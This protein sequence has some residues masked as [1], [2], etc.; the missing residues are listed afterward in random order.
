MCCCQVEGTVTQNADGLE[1]IDRVVDKV[2][3]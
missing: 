2:F 1:Q 3:Q